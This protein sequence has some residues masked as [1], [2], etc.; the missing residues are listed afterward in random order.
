MSRKF[1]VT[2]YHAPNKAYTRRVQD[3]SALRAQPWDPSEPM[4]IGHPIRWVLFQ[5]DQGVIVQNLQGTEEHTTAVLDDGM[6]KKGEVS[7]LPTDNK[8]T[9]LWIKVH[10]LEHNASVLQPGRS[11]EEG[12]PRF[13]LVESFGNANHKIHWIRS[14]TP[15]DT[16]G[17]IR[18]QGSEIARLSAHSSG[19]RVTATADGLRVGTTALKNGSS[20]EL[21][22][23]SAL[24]AEHIPGWRWTFQR[25]SGEMFK[26][27]KGTSHLSVVD[28][29]EHSF[30]K[31]TLLG[32][33]LGLLAFLGLSFLLPALFPPN[34]DELIPTQFAQVLMQAP[35][36]PQQPSAPKPENNVAQAIQ[37]QAVQNSVSQLLKGGMSKLLAQSDFVAGSRLQGA[38]SVFKTA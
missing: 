22:E 38:Q 15:I 32:T 24:T 11:T 25:M 23:T 4:T 16:S 29:M 14:A 30:F 33:G 8:S 26:D 2:T 6:L 5:T 10:A 12:A 36:Q 35:A 3:R 21:Q 17:S 13:R 28:R 34:E 18:H 27:H 1:M 9:P 7:E 19:V 20:I 31:R 37:S